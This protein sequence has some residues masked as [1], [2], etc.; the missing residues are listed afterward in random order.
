VVDVMPTDQRFDRPDEFDLAAYWSETTAAFEA[1]AER[2]VIELRIDPAY[3]GRLV[4]AFGVE[5]VGRAERLEVPDADGWS[6]LRI[7]VEWP[8][9]A[10]ARMLRLSGHAEVLAPQEVRERIIASALSVLARYGTPLPLPDADRSDARR[11]SVHGGPMDEE[12]AERSA[13]PLPVGVSGA[14]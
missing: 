2:G 6:H 1:Q 8:Q 12:D 5:V 7:T 14:S 10:H 13:G 9:D 11:P 4:E 3:M